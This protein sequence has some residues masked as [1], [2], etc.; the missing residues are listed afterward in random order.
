VTH[1]YIKSSSNQCST[2]S[3]EASAAG[4]LRPNAVIVHVD[5]QVSDY[6]TNQALRFRIE[7]QSVSLNVIV[8]GAAPSR[9]ATGLFQPIGTAPEVLRLFRTALQPPSRYLAVELAGVITIRVPLLRTRPGFECLSCGARVPVTVGIEGEVRTTER[10]IGPLG[11][12]PQRDME[13]TEDKI[14]RF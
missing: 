14:V 11:P 7:W 8:K 5:F 12:V 9:S 1:I 3:R 13:Q 2:T 10:T 6:A 4:R